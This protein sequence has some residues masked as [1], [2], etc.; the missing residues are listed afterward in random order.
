M[1]EEM[2]MQVA[3]EQS[4]TQWFRRWQEGNVEKINPLFLIQL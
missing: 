3:V 2:N 4:K 1:R